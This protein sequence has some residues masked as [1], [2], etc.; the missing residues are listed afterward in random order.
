MM[1]KFLSM[2]RRK[3][4]LVIAF[5]MGSIMVLTA[6]AGIDNGNSS[7]KPRF[8]YNG[9]ELTDGTMIPRGGIITVEYDIA[10]TKN[11]RE[12]TVNLP[13][14]LVPVQDNGFLY[15]Y[16]S[17]DELVG[18]LPLDEIINNSI[19]V[20]LTDSQFEAL[21]T[22]TSG[23]SSAKATKMDNILSSLRGLMLRVYAADNIYSLNDAGS[24]NKQDSAI[25][26]GGVEAAGQRESAAETESTDEIQIDEAV[27]ANGQ[28]LTETTEE[29]KGTDQEQTVDQV[30]TTDHIEIIDQE[31]TVG[32]FETTDPI[33]ETEQTEST[34]ATE[35]I[36][37]NE[38]TE[39]TEVPYQSETAVFYEGKLTVEC[40]PDPEL[41]GD[42]LTLEDITISLFAI[43]PYAALLRA[44]YGSSEIPPTADELAGAK[45]FLSVTSYFWVDLYHFEAEKQVEENDTISLNEMLLLEYGFDLSYQNVNTIDDNQNKCY[46]VPIPEYINVLDKVNNLPAELQT[47]DG[48]TFAWLH[49]VEIKGV[50]TLILKFED[51]ISDLGSD[52][53]DC[54]ITLICALDEEQ[55][56][57]AE[58]VEIR[59]TE[60]DT[61]LVNIEENDTNASAL[62]KTG[63]YDPKS[64][65]FKWTIKYLPGR[66][67]DDEKTPVYIGDWIDPSV[68]TLVE[69]SFKI[70]GETVNMGTGKGEYSYEESIYPAPNLK[71]YLPAELSSVKMVTITYETI[72]LQDV[73]NNY[74]T[75]DTED[76]KVRNLAALYDELDTVVGE[77]VYEEVVLRGSDRL[78]LG[79]IGTYYKPSENSDSRGYIEWTLTV[80][81]FGQTFEKLTIFDNIV[82]DLTLET[83]SIMING[84]PLDTSKVTFSTDGGFSQH[85]NSYS[86]YLDFITGGGALEPVYVITYK[87]DVGESYFDGGI[88]VTVDTSLNNAWLE[89]LWPGG[90]GPIGFYNPILPDIDKPSSI[91]SNSLQKD[92]VSYDSSTHVIE[93][94]VTINPHK[95]DFRGGT[96]TD[97]LAARG[98]KYVEGSFSA[99][100]ALGIYESWVNSFTVN[101]DIITLAIKEI[102]TN[103]VTFTFK[104]EVA[105]QN[106]Y[107]G[108][109]KSHKYENIAKMTAN[110]Y[111]ATTNSITAIETEADADISVYSNVLEKISLGYNYKTG[112]II[113]QIT[114]N[115]NK[116]AMPNAVLSDT[117]PLGLTFVKKSLKATTIIDGESKDITSELERVTAPEDD[118]NKLL[119][120]DLGVAANNRT[121]VITYETALDL[122]VVA[123][124]YDADSDDNYI[125][126]RNSVTLSRF[127]FEPVEVGDA[128]ER[129]DNGI[130]TKNYKLIREDGRV[131]YSVNL[132]PHALNMAIIAAAG[133]GASTEVYI[134]DTLPLGML[135]ELESVKLYKAEISESGKFTK[136]EEVDTNSWVLNY[137]AGDAST[138]VQPYFEIKLDEELFDSRLVLEYSAYLFTNTSKI[139][140]NKV[141]LTSAMESV[142]SDIA[143]ILIYKASGGGNININR[144]SIR[145]IK[146][147]KREGTVTIPGV[148][149]ELY[150]KYNG[151]DL[152][153]YTVTTDQNGEAF[154][155]GLKKGVLYTIKES[156]AYLPAGYDASNLF[157]SEILVPDDVDKDVVVQAYN[158]PKRDSFDFTKYDRSDEYFENNTD[159]MIMQ[160]VS[161]TAKDL[162]KKSDVELTVESDENGKVLFKDMPFGIYSITENNAPK[163]FRSIEPFYAVIDT[164]GDFIGFYDELED[165][166]NAYNGQQ[167]DKWT[168]YKVGN[169]RMTFNISITKLDEPRNNYHIPGVKF[170]LY[171]M[172]QEYT[173][174]T[175]PTTYMK[176][177][178]DYVT[179]VNGIVS[180]NGLEQGYYYY[181]YETVPDG[182]SG[183]TNPVYQITPDDLWPEDT[184]PVNVTIKNTPATGGFSLTKYGKGE[185]ET[186]PYLLGGATFRATD[187]TKRYDNVESYYQDVTSNALTGVVT[188]TGLPFGIYKITE[189]S[190]ATYHNA[191]SGINNILFY[192]KIGTN[193]N[194]IGF[195][196]TLAAAEA[197]SDVSTNS[198]DMRNVENVRKTFSLSI[199]KTDSNRGGALVPIKN[200]K[201]TVYKCKDNQNLSIGSSNV[202]G[203]YLYE[204]QPIET[205]SNGV[206]VID[207]NSQEYK[208]LEQGYYYYIFET[209]APDGYNGTDYSITPKLVATIIPTQTN[210]TTVT[211]AVTNE[212]KTG[213][214]S[215]TKYGTEYDIKTE[216]KGVIATFEVKDLTVRNGVAS[217]FSTTVES[218]EETGIVSLTN[219]PFGIYK[220]TEKDTIYYKTGVSFYAKI[221]E[222]GS[223]VGFSDIDSGFALPKDASEQTDETGE[224]YIVQN[225]R[226]TFNL[227][228]SKTD[229]RDRTDVIPVEDAEFALYRVLAGSTDP[230]PKTMD[231]VEN[232][233][234]RENYVGK[235]TDEGSGVYTYDKLEQGYT[236]YVYEMKVPAGYSDNQKAGNLVGTI[237]PF[238]EKD[239]Y[240]L[241][242]T[243]E[244]EPNKGSFLFMK[245]GTDITGEPIGLQGA[246]FEA[247]EVLR[248]NSAV[249]A[250]AESEDGIVEFTDL[251]FGV[252]K[253]NETNAP[254]YYD[255]SGNKPFYAVI[256]KDK[257]F[258]GFFDKQE[259]VEKALAYGI[260]E[261]DIV[262]E[263]DVYN[264]RKT[265]SLSVTKMDSMR[266]RFIKKVTL[267]LYRSDEE[268][269]Q[270]YPVA[271]VETDYIGEAIFDQL[272]QGYQYYIYEL[273]GP[274]GYDY[275]SDL[276]IISF[277]AKDGFDEYDLELEP[278][279]Y[280]I[281][282][283]NVINNT[284][285]TADFS[286]DKMDEND[287]LM[288]DEV[289]FTIKDEIYD[290]FNK[291]V[292]SEDGKFSFESIPFG[293]YRIT[294]TN[295]PDF[296]KYAKDLF[297]VVS[298][299]GNF[300]GFFDTLDEAEIAYED[301]EYGEGIDDVYI[302]KNERK[303]FKLA[304]NKLDS[305]TGLPLEGVTFSI[306]R[307]KS[308]DPDISD[309]TPEEAITLSDGKATFDSSKLYQGY[310][311]FLYETDTPDGYTNN[312]D[313]SNYIAKFYADEGET[314][315][316]Y[317]FVLTDKNERRD[318]NTVSNKPNTGTFSFTKVDEFGTME[319][320][321]FIAT[322]QNEYR[323]D[324]DTGGPVT[325]TRKS[326]KN[327]LVVFEELPFGEYRIVE[328]DDDGTKGKLLYY[329]GRDEFYIKISE[330]GSV[331][332]EDFYRLTQN[333]DLSDSKESVSFISSENGGY[334]FR[335]QH[336]PHV[337]SIIKQDSRDGNVLVEGIKFEVYY[338]QYCEGKED[339]IDIDLGSTDIPGE[340]DPV[341]ESNYKYETYTTG[342]T[343]MLTLIGLAGG[344]WYYVYET[345]TRGYTDSDTPS[346]RFVAAGFAEEDENIEL[347]EY[348]QLLDNDIEY[349]GYSNFVE[350]IPNEGKFSFIKVDENGSAM[351]EIKFTARDMTDGSKVRKIEN[352]DENG[353]VEFSEL[354]FGVYEITETIQKY[355][356]Q[357]VFYVKI[358]ED[359][360]FGGFYSTPDDAESG[361]AITRWATQDGGEI[362]N[363]RKTSDL[364]ITTT[365]SVSEAPIP[366]VI[367]ELYEEG[368]T[369]PVDT[370]TTDA[371]GKIHFRKLKQ[372]VTYEVVE[373]TPEGYKPPA[374]PVVYRF[375][376]DDEEDGYVSTYPIEID[377]LGSIAFNKVSDN[378]DALAGAEF[379]LTGVAED[380]NEIA[381][382]TAISNNDGIVRFENVPIGHYQIL[383]ISAPDNY[384]KDE[385]VYYAEITRNPVYENLFEGLKDEA[386]ALVEG[387][388]VIN[389][390]IDPISYSG[391]APSSYTKQTA[392]S[393]A[394]S[395]PDTGLEG[396]LPQTGQNKILAATL[397]ICGIVLTTIGAYGFRKRRNQKN[398]K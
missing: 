174:V 274:E 339:K 391:P 98:L 69:G 109:T 104:T 172:K 142:G 169:Y 331:R 33:A 396:A 147:D 44:E 160:S 81:T 248:D 181:I 317:D 261:D 101:N 353:K 82:G 252:Y 258:L 180:F 377:P 292:T 156:A 239:K 175:P 250:Q 306:Y 179:D 296:Y 293:I 45:D 43:S 371:E 244:N 235:I 51:E 155:G 74:L 351:A 193:G 170:T 325:Y 99:E 32:Q 242:Y 393:D 202:P 79:K 345:P 73:V 369:L 39:S 321:T 49:L 236:Y 182:Y 116:M 219:L 40:I 232:E 290:D 318:G 168:D 255:T 129:I 363:E 13:V 153:L 47:N 386:G 349:D 375:T 275:K 196:D 335:N 243:I 132:N 346:A 58:S 173:G 395:E 66:L 373:I 304:I 218:N 356:K 394:I 199:T 259:D 152:L 297:A 128:S 163:Y 359:G 295:I 6:V 233:K 388:K 130:L 237:D 256:D 10:L 123:G 62:R 50:K 309:L 158:P 65:T 1:M 257:S 319:G 264:E 222:Y 135:L 83:N 280:Y 265:F 87:T 34:E 30:D 340:L 374:N 78:L 108:N 86:F 320:V 162:T 11:D 207:S 354:P 151:I 187:M 307:A 231:E 149:F 302:F 314:E 18:E 2:V 362:Y 148:T 366:G 102:N 273:S 31:G 190:S 183:V 382:M 365:D 146:Y 299:E 310:W 120:I 97:D 212:P 298:K 35:T 227:S 322:D 380:G 22:D 28:T 89:Y 370:Q 269:S 364:I 185:D 277:F 355:Y 12:I 88:D 214:F 85:E 70:D 144:G 46:I 113:W 192:A 157:V 372:G 282:E 198:N 247:E 100:T 25:S 23:N 137:I 96:L 305:S 341:E 216:L 139:Y 9:Q 272:E 140:E 221:D 336:E 75:Y 17:N 251:P 287:E 72:L 344:R 133:P 323:I 266:Q 397:C 197:A 278:D 308:E 131:D 127:G 286:F 115:E 154:F 311:Y 398:E 16:N 60:E 63:E 177:Y 262:R 279:D 215:F 178:N 110:V 253:I 206:A 392:S 241:E 103:T 315:E 111:N 195:F 324:P 387:N 53:T 21:R 210:T 285:H 376:P 61:L 29:T 80:R 166:Q 240:E 203:S 126:F 200:V 201:F 368:G 303:T 289:E 360:S 223:F 7:M 337:L 361:N 333:E 56:D 246:I 90:V 390:Y 171:K 211:R 217:K 64:G 342:G 117:L 288:W 329:M 300:L 176:V 383:E 184:E 59:F 114:V 188:F 205:G 106:I 136:A 281:G 105:N 150:Y 209:S 381:E 55:V 93:W 332:E 224:A 230:M 52:I 5:V 213:G 4:I 3:S 24:T 225:E 112:T 249:K 119:T 165:A 228:I 186:I 41:E 347:Y 134:K 36:D 301:I 276:A 245:Y 107:G 121:V 191:E 378:S 234:Y 91:I 54:W 124:L 338:D 352:S 159:S 37:N 357:L 316:E 71:Y 15:L 38:T 334:I 343:G 348:I 77:P 238:D 220:I 229:N 328:V 326:D 268:S 27:D 271:R 283:E 145:I 260:E 19:T 14:N 294:E 42:F 76:T 122:D 263:Y 84:N 48:V 312:I 254:D 118:V 92:A 57:D 138:G 8:Y 20:T 385:A 270:Q 267:E 350:N 284:P 204:F 26:L 189:R 67:E 94:R 330:D 143:N 141:E 194:F 167:A 164:E 327:G 313:K 389:K 384:E 358:N 226:K 125:E 161:F 367:Y 208:H 95:V 291:T 68:H 379:R